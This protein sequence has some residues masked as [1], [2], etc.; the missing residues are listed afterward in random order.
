MFKSF[1]KILIVIGVFGSAN[2][3]FAEVTGVSNTSVSKPNA[4]KTNTGHKSVKSQERIITNEAE[5]AEM[6][7]DYERELAQSSI[8]SKT[9]VKMRRA[10]SSSASSS[11]AKPSH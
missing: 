9:S 4:L 8:Q 6:V 3:C 5:Y 10:V 11:S 2:V 1:L 7:K